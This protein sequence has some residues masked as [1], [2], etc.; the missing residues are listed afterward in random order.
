MGEVYLGLWP[1][2]DG[3]ITRKQ[4]PH[5]KVVAASGLCTDIDMLFDRKC[6]SAILLFIEAANARFC[7]L[8]GI[9]Y[10]VWPIWRLEVN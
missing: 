1:C 2:L 9:M 7:I 5:K 3:I 8:R 4:K 10:H 6:P